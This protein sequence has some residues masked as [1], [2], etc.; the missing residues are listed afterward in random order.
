MSCNV[1]NPLYWLLYKFGSFFASSYHLLF[2]QKNSIQHMWDCK[3]DRSFRYALFQCITTTSNDYHRRTKYRPESKW[4]R[5]KLKYSSTSY[6]SAHICIYCMF[7]STSSFVEFFRFSAPLISL[8]SSVLLFIIYFGSVSCSLQMSLCCFCT[9][10]HGTHQYIDRSP[11][12]ML[13][14]VI[15]MLLGV[16]YGT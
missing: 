10:T 12:H 14:C 16:K 3:P 13:I 5:M 6:L 8:T 11:T 7:C 1:G 4:T 15:K 9:N 2:Q